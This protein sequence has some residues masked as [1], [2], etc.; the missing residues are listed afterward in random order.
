[1]DMP[2][3]DELKDLAQRDPESFEILR[4]ALISECIR[5][6]AARNQRR[7][8][9]LQFVIDTR[10]RLA[11]SP[12]KALLEMQALMYDSLLTLQ[13][14]LLDRQCPSPTTQA[15]ARILHFRQPR[16]SADASPS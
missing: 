4:A 5:R 3:F 7:L 14:A 11:A 8:R 9:G 6:S 1:M 16:S 2:T 15:P 13:Q 10:R 12:M